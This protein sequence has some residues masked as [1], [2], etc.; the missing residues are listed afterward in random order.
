MIKL[1]FKDLGEKR[2]MC[3]ATINGTPLAREFELWLNEALQDRCMVDKTYQVT[4]D[5]I[6]YLYEVRGGDI[7]DRAL[8]ALRWV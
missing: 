6:E 7:K 5:T 2:W 3:Y 1:R 4:R 8:L